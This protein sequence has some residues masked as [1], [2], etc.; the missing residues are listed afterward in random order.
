MNKLDQ[1][2]SFTPYVF[3]ECIT[4]NSDTGVTQSRV[5][6]TGKWSWGI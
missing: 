1:E 4:V 5:M 2:V 6:L 3:C